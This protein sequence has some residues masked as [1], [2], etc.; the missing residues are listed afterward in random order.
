MQKYAEECAFR[1]NIRKT[2][3][4]EKFITALQRAEKRL[5]YSQLIAK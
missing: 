5:T 4:T 2:S 3:D 1:Y